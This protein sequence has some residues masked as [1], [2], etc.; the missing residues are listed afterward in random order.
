MM[1]FH[2]A[3]SNPA[4]VSLLPLSH[5]RINAGDGHSDLA[6]IGQAKLGTESGQ[7]QLAA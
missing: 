2:R 7:F 1:R 3:N 5:S 6:R 4:A